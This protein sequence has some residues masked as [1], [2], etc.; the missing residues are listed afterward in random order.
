MKAAKQA[1]PTQFSTFEQSAL[2]RKRIPAVS[3]CDSVGEPLAELSGS[4]FA[5]L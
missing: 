2:E 1:E 3:L 5:T 4:R